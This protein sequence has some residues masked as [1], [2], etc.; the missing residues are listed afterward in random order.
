[1]DGLGRAKQEPEPRAPKVGALGDAWSSYRKDAKNLHYRRDAEDTEKI[2]S[3]T[4]KIATESTEGHR[5][6]INIKREY[7]W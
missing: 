5:K 3:K 1:M 4:I 2:I 6:T 7:V